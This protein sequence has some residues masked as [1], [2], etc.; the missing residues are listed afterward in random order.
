MGAA[1]LGLLT[2][3]GGSTSGYGSSF[4]VG[5]RG[6][7]GG[8]S[9]VAGAAVSAGYGATDNSG[10]WAATNNTHTGND[11]ATPIGTPVTV[12]YGDGVVSQVDINADY[13]TSVMIDHADG[14]Q[15]LYA[16]LS[17]RSVKVGDTVKLGQRL[18]KSGD[19]GNAGGP[20]LHF[21]MRKGKNNPVDPNKYLSGGMGSGS[22]NDML[23]MGY[24]TTVPL[25]SDVLGSSKASTSSS[26]TSSTSSSTPYM[27]SGNYSKN[28]LD[29]NSLRSTL[30]NAGFSG[31]GLEN[32]MKI[33]RAESGGRP[34]AYNGVGLDNSYGL[35]Q[36]NMIGDLGKKRNENYLRDYASIGYT[37]PESLYDPAINS[38]IAYAISNEGTKWGTAWVNSAKKVG[39]G[40]GSTGYGAAM[41]AALTTTESIASMPSTAALQGNKTVNIT[42]NI[43]RASEQEAMRLVRLVKTHLENDKD[44]ARIGNS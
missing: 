35:F 30:T 19:S 15:T 21:E 10:V 17:E 37:G 43:E 11:Y 2:K 39:V 32:A 36:I 24:S 38:K 18:G 41:P 20:H 8:A 40:G 26:S 42:L 33:A 14:T 34:G 22:T 28:A 4:G 25:P 31:Q 1:G 44:L 3:G 6:R 27:G 7:S 13:G 29:D 12:A 23:S 16:H 5:S 9:P